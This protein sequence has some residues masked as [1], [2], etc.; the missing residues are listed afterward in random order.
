VIETPGKAIR[1]LLPGQF[2]VHPALSTNSRDA[3][4]LA[5][6]A[7]W[8]HLLRIAQDM[9]PQ[10]RKVSGGLV[11]YEQNRWL[12]AFGLSVRFA[13]TGDALAESPTDGSSAAIAPV[14]ADGSH[15]SNIHQAMG[16][17]FVALFR[18]I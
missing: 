5:F 9:D 2:P 1:L 12:E 7:V 6:G 15:L 14:T 4:L 17:L 8:A 18:E 11:E 16:N 10:K 3:E 13:G